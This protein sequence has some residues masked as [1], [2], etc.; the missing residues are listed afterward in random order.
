MCTFLDSAIG[1]TT[2]GP[3][4]PDTQVDRSNSIV[5]HLDPRLPT[6]LHL[7]H[8]RHN[9]DAGTDLANACCGQTSGKIIKTVRN[10]AHGRLPSQ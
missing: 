1:V 10:H 4:G 6:P 3:V 2:L 8:N 9:P 7:P 5:G